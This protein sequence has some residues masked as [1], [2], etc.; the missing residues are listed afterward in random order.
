MAPKRWIEAWLPAR[1]MERL[2]PRRTGV[3]IVVG[4]LLGLIFP[5]AVG[6]WL[7][8]ALIGGLLR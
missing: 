3:A 8:E 4:G 2:L 6:F 1:L 5:V 7:G